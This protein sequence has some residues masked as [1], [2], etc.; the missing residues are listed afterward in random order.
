MDK[1]HLTRLLVVVMMPSTP[2]SPKLVL[3]NT[4]QDPSF[5]ISNQLSLIKLE[6][7]PTDNSFILNNL[8]QAKK[9]LPTTSPEDT[10]PLVKK[11]L[12][13]ALTESEN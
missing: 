8:F 5:S 13:F 6:L 3:E 12:I 2:F 11:L 10:T 1:C 4:S 7:E 9:M